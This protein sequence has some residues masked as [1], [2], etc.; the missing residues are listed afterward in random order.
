MTGGDGGVVVAHLDGASFLV[1]K[2]KKIHMKVLTCCRQ[3]LS[4]TYQSFNKPELGIRVIGLDGE[5]EFGFK[6]R[7]GV[8]LK[9]DWFEF[10]DV[11]G[12]K[13]GLESRDDDGE[14]EDD[15]EED[16]EEAVAAETEAVG[17]TTWSFV[18][19]CLSGDGGGWL[20]HGGGRR[21]FRGL[22]VV[23]RLVLVHCG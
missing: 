4:P 22:G 1:R 7:V 13:R 20:W 10:N 11:N 21:W 2:T 9:L 15:G 23:R 17:G 18:G 8:H 14:D 19:A 6:D 5:D 16:Y 3:T 12:G